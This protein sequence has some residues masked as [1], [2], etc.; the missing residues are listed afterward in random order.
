MRDPPFASVPTRCRI[1]LRDEYASG[2]GTVFWNMTGIHNR[3]YQTN[4]D[5]GMHMN[6]TTPS[7]PEAPQQQDNAQPSQPVIQSNVAQPNASPSNDAPQP[8][9]S[10]NAQQPQPASTPQQPSR[11]WWFVAYRRFALIGA[12][13]AV[14]IALWIGLNIVASGAAHQFFGA[15]QPT[16]VS[17]LTSSGPM[18]LIAIPLSMLIFTLVPAVKTRQYTLKGGEFA[19]LLIMCV[20]VMMLGNLIGQLMA[21]VASQG[22]ASDRVQQLLVGGDA[23]AVALFAGVL[24]PI[25]EEWIFRKEIISRLRRYGEKT[26]IVF[27]A[28]AFALFHLNIYQFFY[29]F[30]LGL[31]FG[32][33]YT[34]TSRLW[35]V[36]VMH[37]FINF[38]GG[39]IGP[40]VIRL[41]DPRV[42][43]G[44][45]SESE[46]ARM[47]SSG[48]LNGLAVVSIYYVAMLALCIAGI[49]LLVRWRNR[50]EFYTAPEELPAGLKIRTAYA[51]PGV[52][53]YV[54]LTLALTFWMLLQ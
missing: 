44:T 17:L 21:A 14:M 28:L 35:Y 39:V 26:A 43:N 19:Q 38:L 45:L 25:F 1:A 6:E 52:I 11:D 10:P 23:W 7:A 51:N 30:G 49:V 29:A 4:D 8:D 36:I 31:I 53:V 42:L 5:G 22:Q 2:I 9:A 3:C 24:A 13:L 50:W 54:L 34:R 20:P 32:Y 37:M 40:A 18:Y 41:I 16:W 33:V 15:N 48:Q 46:V 12:A 27:S 47:A